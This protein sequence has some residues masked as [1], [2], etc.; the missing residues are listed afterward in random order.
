MDLPQDIPPSRSAFRVTPTESII[1]SFSSLT[2]P[3]KALPRTNPSTYH[4]SAK[5]LGFGASVCTVGQW[6]QKFRA[7]TGAADDREVGPWELL[8]LAG[9]TQAGVRASLGLSC[10]STPSSSFSQPLTFVFALRWL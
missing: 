2:K 10:G 5:D 3:F 1:D 7:K 4:Q 8:A 6:P 9:V